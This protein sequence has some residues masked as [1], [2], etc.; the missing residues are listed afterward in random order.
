MEAARA[1]ATALPGLP[2]RASSRASSSARSARRGCGRRARLQGAARAALAGLPVLRDAGRARRRRSVPLA[3]ARA[4]PTRAVAP[5]RRRRLRRAP[6]RLP[7]PMAVERTLILVKPDAVERGLAGEISRASSGAGSRCARRG[8]SASTAARRAALRRARRE[9]VLRRARRLHHLGADARARARGRGRD[10]VVAARRS[11]PRTRPTPAPGTIR[12]DLALAMPNNLVHGSDSP[13]SAAREIALWFRTMSSSDADVRNRALLGPASGRVPGAAPRA[14]RA[15]TSRAGGSG[16][17]PSASCR[18]SATWPART[19]S[20]SAAAPRSGRS[21]SPRRGARPRRGRQLRRASSS[22]RAGC[23]PRR[24]ST[25]RSCTR[26]PSRRAVPGRELRPRLLR[27]RRDDLRRPATAS[28]P[29]SAR[30]LR[31][32][33]APRVLAHRRRSRW[34]CCWTTRPTRSCRGSS[35]TTS[36]CTATRTGRARSTFQLPYGEW[37]RLFRRNGLR[38]RGPDRAAA[39]RGCETTYGSTT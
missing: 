25:S 21:C 22:T 35:A 24:A 27:L 12:G 39:A 28:C 19:S 6:S 18:S 11:A 3:R 32:R 1:G 30:L 9:A 5:P 16:S 33:R 15:A 36:A 31:P 26:A 37:I 13:E 17:S 4:A 2:R 29:R 14:H 10:R 8:S 38:G 34:I 7:P 20:S 23:W